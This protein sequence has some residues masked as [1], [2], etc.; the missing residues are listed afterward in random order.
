LM[1]ESSSL[2]LRWGA[3]A[4]AQHLAKR[5]PD[6]LI[7]RSVVVEQPG[8]PIVSDGIPAEL[9]LRTVLKASQEIAGEMELNGLLAKLMNIVIQSS[10]AQQGYLILEQEGRWMIEAEAAT[11]GPAYTRPSRDLADTESLAQSV[12]HYAANTQETIVLEDASQS[13]EFVQDPYVQQHRVRSVLCTPLINRARTSGI[14]YLENNLAPH[15]FSPQRVS[16][17]RLL[18][19][20]MAISIDNA[21]A[22]AELESLL[23]S[24][25]KALASA[26]VQIRT[27]FEDSPLGI[28]LST[29]E[30]RFLSV[31]KAMLKM[32]RVTEEELLERSVVDFYH[33]PND[34]V[35]LLRRV[36]ESGFVQDFGVQL[37]RHD[38]STFGPRRTRAPGTRAARRRHPD[39]SFGRPAG[40]CNGPHLGGG[41]CGRDSTPDEA[42]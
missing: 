22:R 36:E 40:R 15:V 23:E 33:D 13:G 10:G 28:A 4:K 39:H 25:S 27:L 14:L 21:R 12:V 30:G 42:E 29:S 11:E 7:G 19:S 32:L 26:E 20:Q 9:D 18:S 31:N 6:F 34:R 8:T 16:L 24:R 35:A 17:L 37:V 41:P 3:L 1:R 2:Y 5:F 38:G